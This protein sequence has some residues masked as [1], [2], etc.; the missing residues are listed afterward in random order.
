V[1]AL[2][3]KELTSYNTMRAIRKELLVGASMAYFLPFLPARPR[4]LFLGISGESSVLLGG[5]IAG[6]MVINMMVAGFLGL[7]YPF[8][9]IVGG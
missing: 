9:L 1:R 3:T 6:A 8:C 7:F 2:A 5:I 4:C